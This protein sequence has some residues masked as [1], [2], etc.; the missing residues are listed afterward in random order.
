M[1]FQILFPGLQIAQAAVCSLVKS[2]PDVPLISSD[3]IWKQQQ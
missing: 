1:W 3:V 2:D